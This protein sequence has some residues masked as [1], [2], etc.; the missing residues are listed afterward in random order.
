MTRSDR[1]QQ[2][3][4]ADLSGFPT[5]KLLKDDVV[6]RSTKVP[7]GP[8][9]FASGGGRFDLEGTQGTLYVGR[10]IHCAAMERIGAPQHNGPLDASGNPSRM[11]PPLSA[12]AIDEAFART[13]A[14]F[15]LRA[16]Q[17]M[18]LADLTSRGAGLRFG[19]TGELSSGAGADAYSVTVEW[20]AALYEGGHDGV[21][22]HSRFVSSTERED[23][24]IAVFGRAGNN[25]EPFEQVEETTLYDAAFA[26][27]VIVR[28]AARSVP[29][30][31]TTGM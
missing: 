29:A 28:P 24:A 16:T 2:S 11:P 17:S 4:P 18:N 3:P 12:G 25:L 22:Y 7:N 23:N 10:S 6:Y 31:T 27:G 9:F 1:A 26:A 13:I 19:V 5:S 21:E 30:P 15:T 20:A 8:G 14:I